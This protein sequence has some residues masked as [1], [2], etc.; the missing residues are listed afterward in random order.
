M[1]GGEGKAWVRHGVRLWF[2]GR[3]IPFLRLFLLLLALILLHLV[4][5][6][7]EGIVGRRKVARG[8]AMAAEEM[9]RHL[10]C[11]ARAALAT[12]EAP[13]AWVARVLRDFHALPRGVVVACVDR[14]LPLSHLHLLQPG[15]ALGHDPED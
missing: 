14:A 5:S 11:R 7:P 8:R 10:G 12:A 9:I 13:P 3:G 6:G 2:D 4:E 15:G 1:R